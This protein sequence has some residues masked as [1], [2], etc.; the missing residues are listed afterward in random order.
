MAERAVDGLEPASEVPWVT[1]QVS[2]EGAAQI[3]Q[4]RSE[5][6]VFYAAMRSDPNVKFRNLPD[7]DIS[8]LR[9]KDF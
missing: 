3:H 2:P 9:S 5:G 4:A 6:K 7:V 1:V 8:R